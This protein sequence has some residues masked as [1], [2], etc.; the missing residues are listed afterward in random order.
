MTSNWSTTQN[1]FRACINRNATFVRLLASKV[2][3]K[4]AEGIH[5][6]FEDML[7][8]TYILIL[9]GLGDGAPRLLL[10]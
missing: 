4:F 3:Q 7:R 5:R 2:P 8:S 6:N 9:L 1:V 10:I